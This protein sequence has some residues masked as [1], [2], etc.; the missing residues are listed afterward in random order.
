MSAALIVAILGVVGV[1]I[2]AAGGYFV[3][4]RTTS[5]TISTTE[6][7][8]LWAQNEKLLDRYEK[9]AIEAVA[10]AEMLVIEKETTRV[11]ME[12]LRFELKQCREE[13][14]LL[15][16]KFQALSQKKPNPRKRAGG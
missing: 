10:R 11:E 16:L 6:A 8:T 12:A 13:R 7:D 14:A 2:T 5:G 4:K 1:A 15:E 9:T 3:A